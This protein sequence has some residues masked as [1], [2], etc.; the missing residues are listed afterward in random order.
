MGR[1]SFGEQNFSEFPASAK[2]SGGALADV[3]AEPPK[4]RAL[5]VEMRMPASASGW[6]HDDTA[7]N[8]QETIFPQQ[9]LSWSFAKRPRKPKP[10]FLPKSLHVTGGQR[11]LRF[12]RGGFGTLW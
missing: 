1:T 7:Y 12:G 10:C 4:S 11:T 8:T 5:P 9:P 6:Q 2:S 3:G